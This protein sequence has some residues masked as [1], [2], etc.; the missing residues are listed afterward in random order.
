M[1]GAL[2]RDLFRPA[3]DQPAPA[4]LRR[5]VLNVGG[6]SKSIAIPAHFDGWE[7]LLLDIDARA[8]PDIVCDARE[9]GALAAF[10]F[11]AIYCSHNLEHYYRHDGA[12]VLQ[13]FLHVLKADGFAEIRV[14]DIQAV[15]RRAV[16]GGMDL[17]DV[18]YEAAVGPIAV[19]DV[20]YGYGREIEASGNDYYAHKTGFSPRLLRLA[21]EAAGFAR[22]FVF[23]SSGAI[24][25]RALAFKSEPTPLQRELLG[26]DSTGSGSWG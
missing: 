23:A 13:G 25:I 8:S 10:Q 3:K 2:L 12:K 20:I 16:D 17:D 7:H 21:L 4:S 5:R 9:L 24:E 18:L 14:P 15:M 22:I 26:L 11:D 1:L 6:G 19:G